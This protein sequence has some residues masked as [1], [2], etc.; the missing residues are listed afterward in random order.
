MKGLIGAVEEL[1]IIIK[2][3]EDHWST[4]TRERKL[5]NQLLHDKRDQLI[6]LVKSWLV[7]VVC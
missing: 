1:Q 5:A 7:V 2:S 6:S 3:P 4:V